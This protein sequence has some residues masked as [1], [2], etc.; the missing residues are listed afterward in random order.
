MPSTHTCLH[1]HL[2]FSTKNRERV[3]H[4]DWR[5]DLHAY[6]GG[7][8]KGMEG[9]PLVIGGVSD[10]VHLLIRLNPKNCLSDVMREMK[11]ASSH[12]VHQEIGMGAFAWQEGYGAFAVSRSNIPAVAQYV[13]NQEQHHRRRTFQEEYVELLQ[14]HE[15]AYDEKYLW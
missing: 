12:W 11:K 8:V 14:R 10:H 1:Y 7:C 4:A 9:D 13:E 2:V 5:G 3:I 6:L 15:I